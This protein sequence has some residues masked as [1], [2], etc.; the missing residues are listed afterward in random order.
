MRRASRTPTRITSPTPRRVEE[1]ELS[2]DIFE[3]KHAL[4]A[5]LAEL[6]QTGMMHIDVVD[7]PTL[8]NL[9]RQIGEQRRGYHL[10]HYVGHARPDHLI[11]E[12]RSGERKDL[13]SSQFMEVLRLCPDCG[14][15]SLPDARPRVPVATG[16]A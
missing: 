15:P 7:R 16:N 10:F 11:L 9:R 12:D 2:F 13:G 6:Q 4:L 14:W 8:D 1:D 5:E 3:V